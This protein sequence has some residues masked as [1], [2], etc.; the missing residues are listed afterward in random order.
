MVNED[1]HEHLQAKAEML[2]L[3]PALPEGSDDK[4]EMIQELQAQIQQ[5]KQLLKNMT[6]RKEEGEG[7]VETASE[8][9]EPPLRTQQASSGARRSIVIKTGVD[10]F[11]APAHQLSPAL[12]VSDKTTMS[13][14]LAYIVLYRKRTHSKPSSIEPAL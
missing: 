7:G 11:A 10:Q 5:L 2:A 6:N 13:C 4:D 12:E 1:V 14:S 3:L 9:E 8:E